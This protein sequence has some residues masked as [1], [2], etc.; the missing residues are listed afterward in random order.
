MCKSPYYT[1][2]SWGCL[3]LGGKDYIFAASK[4]FCGGFSAG[5]DL[6]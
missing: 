3:I 2:V 1:I 4:D 6:F 5:H